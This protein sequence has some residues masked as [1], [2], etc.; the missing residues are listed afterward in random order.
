MIEQQCQALSALLDGDLPAHRVPGLLNSVARDSELRDRWERYQLIGTALRGEGIAMAYR[1]IA[2][3]VRNRIAAEPSLLVPAVRQR[4]SSRFGPFAGVAL[5]ASIAFLAVFA[6]PAL[7]EPAATSTRGPAIA[8]APSS[9]AAPP[10]VRGSERFRDSIPQQRWHLDQ[11]GIENKLDHLLVSHQEFA[12]AT[13]ING[14]LPYATLV[15]YAS[16]R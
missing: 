13:G 16:G 10:Q 8:Q 3:W 4:H 14:M 6:V 5:A 7:F 9:T 2:P 12:P 15:S 1:E 11:P